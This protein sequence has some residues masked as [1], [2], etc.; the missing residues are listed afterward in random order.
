L[1]F[2][3][4]WLA[5]VAL[6]PYLAYLMMR[7]RSSTLFTAAN[8]GIASGGAVGE[9]KSAI[10]MHLLPIEGAVAAY[11][12]VPPDGD[13]GVRAR[14]A[15]RWIERAHIAFP[16]VLKPDVGERG[17]GV[18]LI[19]APC[20]VERYMDCV[21]EAVIVQR[22]V[23]G[24]EAG[25]F[26]CRYP[27]A[28][29]GSIVSIAQMH[30]RHD[31]GAGDCHAQVSPPLWP[32]CQ[33]SHSISFGFGCHHANFTDARRWN[34]SQLERSIDELARKVP[35]FHFGRFDVRASSIEA[36]LGG[37]FFVIELNGVFAEATHIYDPEICLTEA[38][39]TLFRQWRAA[40]EIGAENRARGSTPMP[41]CELI[42]L[43]ATKVSRVLS[44]ASL[45]D[46]ARGS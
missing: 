17:W 7:Y 33:R 3:R 32:A 11:C 31:V 34:T 20:D 26:Y 15:M 14:A 27:D 1:R 22:Y 36:L 9:S 16:V 18:A 38:C 10:L 8:P 5:Y 4:Q 44:A 41:P 28:R 2:R 35:G 29:R 42:A 6:V 37:E 23:S 24:I 25:I 40:F 12:L 43:L 39:T 46:L 13:P 21:K 19:R 45:R 30:Y